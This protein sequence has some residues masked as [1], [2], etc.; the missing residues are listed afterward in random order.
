[1]KLSK[2]KNKNNSACVLKLRTLSDFHVRDKET[3]SGGV[4]LAEPAVYPCTIFILLE[5]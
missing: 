4:I 5:E 2:K 3:V 1:M